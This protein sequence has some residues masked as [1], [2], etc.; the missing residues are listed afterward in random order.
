MNT[1]TQT[2]E[3]NAASKEFVKSF[4]LYTATIWSVMVLGV[5]AFTQSIGVSSAIEILSSRAGMIWAPMIS[6]LASVLIAQLWSNSAIKLF[7]PLCAVILASVFFPVK[8]AGIMTTPI[9]ELI[10]YLV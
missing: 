4:A 1:T 3:N 9:V 10:K 6:F 5:F 2:S 7:S 8:H